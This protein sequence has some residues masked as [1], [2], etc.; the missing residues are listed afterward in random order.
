MSPQPAK[1]VEAVRGGA[2]PGGARRAQG[3][4]VRSGDIVGQ[5]CPAPAQLREGCGV[6]F[7][8]TKDVE[9]SREA[10]AKLLECDRADGIAPVR[11]VPIAQ[12]VHRLGAFGTGRRCQP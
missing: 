3:L 9:A 2:Q 5:Q 1:G 6:F 8:V 10:V 11:A 4:L 7:A 12:P